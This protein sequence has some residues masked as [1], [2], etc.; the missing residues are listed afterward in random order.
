MCTIGIVI[1]SFNGFTDTVECIDSI[2]KADKANFNISILVVENGDQKGAITWEKL[3]NYFQTSSLDGNHTIHIDQGITIDVIET[4]YNGGFG[5]GNNI[6]IKYFKRIQPSLII[7]LN[8]DT[9]V[10]PGFFSNIRD[11]ECIRNPYQKFAIG[12]TS[13]NYYTHTCIDSY[14][15]GYFDY[16]TGRSSHHKQYRTK[17]ITGS[18]VIMN[19]VETIPYFDENFFLYCED[20]DYSQSLINEGYKL[21]Y[22]PSIIIFHKV[23]ASTKHNSKIEKIKLQSLKYLLMK[24]GTAKN[25]ISFKLSRT[26]YYLIKR[27]ITLLKELWR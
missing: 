27:E 3:Y 14:G 24:R 8:N 22:D 18:C 26:I 25:I 19:N 2:L 9:I 21:E 7:L 10:D 15:Y 4:H 12:V 6:G 23:S 17:Y 16:F 20:V 1:V 11:S 13:I 5:Y